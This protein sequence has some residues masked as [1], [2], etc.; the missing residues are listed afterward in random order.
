MDHYNLLYFTMGKV[1][2]ENSASCGKTPGAASRKKQ[3]T[4][5]PSTQ[6]T[7]ERSGMYQEAMTRNVARIGKSM[8]VV[9]FANLAGQQEALQQKKFDLQMRKLECVGNVQI[10]EL[11]DGRIAA[12]NCSIEQYNETMAFNTVGP[13][14]LHFGTRQPRLAVEKT[15][16]EEGYSAEADTT[17]EEDEGKKGVADC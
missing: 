1:S 3:K 15:N 13:K 7:G 12:I 10:T 14:K 16:N 4:K 9:A 6:K 2:D 5:D 11:I 17:R 8:E